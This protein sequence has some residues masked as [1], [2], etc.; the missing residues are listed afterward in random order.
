MS[1]REKEKIVQHR[2]CKVCGKAI[3]L[4][5]EFCSR[6]CEISYREWERRNRRLT[7][8]MYLVLLII[9]IVLMMFMAVGI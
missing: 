9:F 5:R 6:Q 7:T 4:D 3:P 2:H 8:I 1:R